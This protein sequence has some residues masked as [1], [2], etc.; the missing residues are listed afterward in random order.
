MI[1]AGG[2]GEKFSTGDLSNQ[3][4]SVHPLLMAASLLSSVDGKIELQKVTL[5]L[6]KGA[7]LIFKLTLHG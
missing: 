7:L 6:I 3:V 5:E 4:W 1:W 2:V